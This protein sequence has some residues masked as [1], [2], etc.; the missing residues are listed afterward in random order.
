MKTYRW[1]LWLLSC[2]CGWP[3]SAQDKPQNPAMSDAPATIARWQ[4]QYTA[5]DGA[6]CTQLG[7]HYFAANPAQAF[8]FMQKAC[9]LNDAWGCYQM[10][11]QYL[12]GAGVPDNIKSARQWMRHAC[13]LKQGQAS[14]I[15][16]NDAGYLSEQAGHTADA[17]T[18]YNTACSMNDPRGCMN[19]V[20]YHTK[21]Y[22]QHPNTQS[23]AVIQQYFDR[24]CAIQGQA[25]I[26][27]AA[28]EIKKPGGM[29][30]ILQQKLS[31]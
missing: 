12:H 27:T 17:L 29:L 14:A 4:Q 21:Q 3:V 22:Q 1:L 10:G 23:E 5:R 30:L 28:A 20:K 11:E 7:L 2:F 8:S 25:Q 13:I 15:A 24:A 16:C 26:C 9:Q 18:L 19:L 31:K 6:A